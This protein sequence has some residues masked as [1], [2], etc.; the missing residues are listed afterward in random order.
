[1]DVVLKAY[2]AG[3]DPNVRIMPERFRK[4]FAD[5]EEAID[6]VCRLDPE[7]SKGNRDRVIL[8]AE[9]FLETSG[10]GVEFCIATTAA[11]IWWDARG[12]S[13]WNDWKG[14]QLR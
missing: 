9:P 5:K 14:G 10:R 12:A 11:I 7:R 8:N 3:Y 1:M 6:W 4:R 13:C 2:A